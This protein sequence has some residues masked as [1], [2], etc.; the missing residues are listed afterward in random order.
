MYELNNAPDGVLEREIRFRTD[1]LAGCVLGGLT[2]DE[3]LAEWARRAAAL[4]DTAEGRRARR[5]VVRATLDYMVAAYAVGPGRAEALLR[6]KH[7]GATPEESPQRSCA[8]CGAP[9]GGR[10]YCCQACKQRAHRARKR[11]NAT[12]TGA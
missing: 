3:L 2:T 5:R 12:V 8:S 9:S 10:M 1:A 4:G 11:G 6:A 7:Q